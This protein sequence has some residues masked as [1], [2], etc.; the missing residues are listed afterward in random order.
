M[1]E[2]PLEYVYLISVLP[3]IFIWILIF[4]FRKDLRREILTMSIIIGIAGVWAQYQWWTVD[5]W[6]PATITGTKIGIEDFILGFFGGGI[7]TVAYEAILRQKTDHTSKK[8]TIPFALIILG[9]VAAIGFFF[10]SLSS[11]F[12]TTIGL[13]FASVY[14]FIK[15]KHLIKNGVATGLLTTGFALLFYVWIYILNP[16]WAQNTY[17]YENLSGVHILDFPIE[18]LVFWFLS[19][20]FIGPLY[21]YSKKRR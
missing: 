5:W 17:L 8:T 18:E 21:E 2:I 9:T 15:Q 4:Y 19:G 1:F 16:E 10:F 13:I 14:I 7:I 20:L 12:A 6:Q 3:L 11:F